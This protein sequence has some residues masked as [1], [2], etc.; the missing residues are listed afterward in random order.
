MHDFQAHI[1]IRLASSTSN[2]AKLNCSL[3]KDEKKKNKTFV[4]VPLHLSFVLN[5]MRFINFTLSIFFP[6]N[7]N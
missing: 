7:F 6:M 3:L 2:K 5:A 4:L 1:Q